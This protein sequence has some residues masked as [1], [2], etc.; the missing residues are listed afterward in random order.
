VPKLVLRVAEGVPELPAVVQSDKS[1]QVK[2][3]K[4]VPANTPDSDDL[5]AWLVDGSFLEKNG[6]AL[7]DLHLEPGSVLLWNH[8]G[9]APA[10]EGV[11][12]EEMLFEEVFSFSRPQDFQR[13]LKNLF[14]RLHL[15]RQLAEKDRLLR[16]KESENSELL[17][18]GIA[19]S[20]ERDN[21]KLLNDILSQ[22]RQ[23]ARADAG[24]LYLLK[25]DEASGEQTLLFKI[26]Q[27]DSNPPQDYKEFVLIPTKKMIS[28]YVALT[29][30]VLNIEDA[31]KI[32]ADREYGF[33]PGIDKS[34]G[35][36]TKSMLTVP[37]QDHKGAILGV[38]Q[39]INCKI[40]S[41]LRIKSAEDADR[42]VVPFSRDIEPVVLSLA[43]QA[44]VSLENNN[45]YIEI[46]RLFEGFVKASVK[47][48]ESRDPTTS[49]HSNR[50]AA[51]TVDLAKA[52][53]LASSGAYK[54][55]SFTP[56][57]MKEIRYASLLHDFGK[58]GVR[59]HVLVKAEKLYPDQLK[60]V[61]MRLGRIRQAM[62][63]GLLK[64]RFTA[65]L[66]GGQERYQQIREEVERRES[67]YLGEIDR[68]LQTIE[69]ANI[70]SVLAASPLQILDE[71]YA[72]RFI[73]GDGEIPYLTD[74]EYE[75]LKIPKGSLDDDER[76]EIESHV[77]HTYDFLKTIPWTKEMRNIPDIA[78]GHH[79]KLTGVGY[80]RKIK[81]DQISIQT[82]MMTVSDIYDALTASDRPYKKAVP[83]QK[84]LDILNAEV[85]DKELDPDLVKIF[86]EAKI[87]QAKADP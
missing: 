8:G 2:R 53:T 83:A 26:T 58:V 60:L 57:H 52:V 39:L 85:R 61:Q 24:T 48:I 32:P 6:K 16:A 1:L 74:D 13:T 51:Y 55:V 70:P 49:G 72:K 19:L 23:I 80:P 43:S 82:R 38:I 47:A 44:A 75:K 27:N 40:D 3:V 50:V 12:P 63:Y 20:A 78:Y 84:A 64:E 5:V 67:E 21:D 25:H 66:E 34:T 17:K 35:Y 56:E 46:E 62:R 65:L 33:N 45:L 41:G 87:W 76:I 4:R 68:Y 7:C 81:G 79:E 54:D 73:E 9:K 15:E 71:I 37:M 18:V 29:G 36:H 31:Y 11:L 69:T 42:H 14:H 30:T 10:P 59:E 28:G 86:V 77:K 22:L